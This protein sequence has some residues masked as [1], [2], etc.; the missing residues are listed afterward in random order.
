MFYLNKYKK[1]KMDIDEDNS[2]NMEC[3]E[4]KSNTVVTKHIDGLDWPNYVKIENGKCMIDLTDKKTFDLFDAKNMIFAPFPCY[5]KIIQLNLSKAKHYLNQIVLMSPYF[6][7]VVQTPALYLLLFSKHWNAKNAI[8]SSIL[9]EL[10]KEINQPQLLEHFTQHYNVLQEGWKLKQKQMSDCTKPDFKTRS[11]IKRFTEYQQ[12]KEKLDKNI[13]LLI[14]KYESEYINNLC[15]K[16][17]K[18]TNYTDINERDFYISVKMLY[19]QYKTVIH[20]IRTEHDMSKLKDQKY[21]AMSM[22]VFEEYETAQKL[23]VERQQKRLKQP[24]FDY[25]FNQSKGISYDSNSK[26]F[27]GVKNKPISI[28]EAEKFA[29]HYFTNVELPYMFTDIKLCEAVIIKHLSI[30]EEKLKQSLKLKH[31]I[32]A[33]GEVPD[34]YL[35]DAIFLQKKMYEKKNE[36]FSNEKKPKL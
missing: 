31:C 4:V 16:N 8:E 29:E 21:A 6:N 26:T 30:E 23:M 20:C 32:F 5:N 15:D 36:Y 10:S 12:E 17:K 28:K 18:N 35:D 14:D 9:Q 34:K 25:I 2:M 3:D 7:H 24:P 22:S 13:Q 11:F 19:H 27:S 1:N 33:R